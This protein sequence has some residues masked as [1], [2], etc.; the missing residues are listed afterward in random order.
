MS[1]NNPGQI[2]GYDFWTLDNSIQIALATVVELLRAECRSSELA[3]AIESWALCAAVND[4]YFSVPDNWAETT[5]TELLQVID[6]AIS[7]VN[8]HGDYLS[9]D[10]DNWYILDDLQVTGGFLRQR[11][12]PAAS[13]IEFLEGF[14]AMIKGEL[15]MP[16]EGESIHL[17]YPCG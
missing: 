13:V 6:Q 16:P 14:A 10:V 15:P 9:E 1:R 4:V 2:R 12:Y 11:P 7:K 8:I 17:G 3:E 5:Y